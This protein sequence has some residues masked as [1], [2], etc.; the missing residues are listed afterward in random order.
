[1][2]SKGKFNKKI[3]YGISLIIESFFSKIEEIKVPEP[4]TGLFTQYEVVVLIHEKL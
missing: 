2:M 1:M 3:F 4:F